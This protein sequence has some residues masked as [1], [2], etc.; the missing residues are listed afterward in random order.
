L[1][2]VLGAFAETFDL[3]GALLFSFLVAALLGAGVCE[4]EDTA[5]FETI[6]SAVPFEAIK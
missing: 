2:I 6:G 5:V 4:D 1:E 3:S